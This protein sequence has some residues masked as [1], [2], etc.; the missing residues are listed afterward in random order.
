MARACGTG[1]A[2]PGFRLLTQIGSTNDLAV[3][4]TAYAV[5]SLGLA[6]VFTLPTVLIVSSEP[7]EREGAAAAISEMSA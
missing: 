3:M 6:L 2:A 5:F 4:V 1:T 7:P